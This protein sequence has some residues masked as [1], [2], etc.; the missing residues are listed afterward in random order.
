VQPPL[1]HPHHREDGPR[2]CLTGHN[3]D[4]KAI[5]GVGEGER[6][7]RCV[8]DFPRELKKK[9]DDASSHPCA[10][11]GPDVVLLDQNAP[12]HPFSVYFVPLDKFYTI[13]APP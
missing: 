8:C 10:E 1:P 11:S 9:K 6:E 12:V 3:L 4:L 13:R 2:R 5:P 7:E